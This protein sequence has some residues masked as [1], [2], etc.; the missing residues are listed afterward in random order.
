MGAKDGSELAKASAGRGAGVTDHVPDDRF[1]NSPFWAPLT[2]DWPSATHVPAAGHATLRSSTS[3]G[4]VPVGVGATDAVQ[5]P[6]A[7]LSST[8][9]STPDTVSKPV[10]TQVLGSV[11][12]TEVSCTSVEGCPPGV[13]TPTAVH[14]P[15]DSV[16][17][18]PS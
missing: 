5:V 1:Q 15:P 8:P 6:E 13:G 11:H 18:S 9:C 17:R 14:A 16:S 12:A 7:R 3:P 2:S 4:G 10:A